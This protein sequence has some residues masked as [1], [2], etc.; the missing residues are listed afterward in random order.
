MCV[1]QV[2]NL[3]ESDSTGRIYIFLQSKEKKREFNSERCWSMSSKSERKTEEKPIQNR[4][5]RSKSVDEQKSNPI[6]TNWSIKKD[7]RK[8]GGNTK[9][10][11]TRSF[12][13]NSK[14]TSSRYVS[15]NQSQ[16]RPE[17]VSKVKVAFDNE[18]VLQ[19]LIKAQIEYLFSDYHLTND[20]YLLARMQDN[21]Q[22]W[23]SIDELCHNQKIRCLTNKKER[24]V[25]ALK[26][27][28]YLQLSP[29]HDRVRRPD[30][31]LPKLKPN[32]D[33]RRTVFLYGI[34]GNKR[35][36]EIRK[37]LSQYGHIKRIHFDDTSESIINADNDDEAP[38]KSVA[39]LIMKKKFLFPSS[40]SSRHGAQSDHGSDTDHSSYNNNGELYG[41]PVTNPNGDDHDF[42]HLKTCF[43][44]F[45]SQSQATKCVRARVR[46]VDGMRCIHKYDYNKVAKKFRT[47]QMKGEK[48]TFTPPPNAHHVPRTRYN[49]SNNTRQYQSYRDRSHNN[50]NSS[51]NRY[52]PRSRSSN[53]A[54]S[55]TSFYNAGIGRKKQPQ[56]PQH[57][58][59]GRRADRNSHDN[60][61]SISPK[62][63][64][65]QN[66]TNNRKRATVR[67]ATPNMKSNGAIVP[68]HHNKPR[69]QSVQPQP[70]PQLYH[71]I[72]AACTTTTRQEAAALQA[73]GYQHELYYLPMD[74]PNLNGI[75]DDNLYD[76][77]VA[78]DVYFGVDQHGQPTATHHAAAQL[79]AQS[80]SY[81]Q[82]HS[83][84]QPRS[85]PY[86]PITTPTNPQL[87]YQPQQWQLDKLEKFKAAKANANKQ[88]NTAKQQSKIAT[89]L[90]VLSS[91]H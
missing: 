39:Q 41:H 44:V 43:V 58:R 33:L 85:A 7:V 30:F 57:H 79:Q 3:F 48:L 50:S 65:Y 5:I 34:A 23:L 53:N 28:K 8:N 90:S 86:G 6:T 64:I 40:S 55:S 47:A 32:R 31:T 18:L 13:K 2:L 22:H 16:S 88:Q 76:P 9:H 17:R 63:I 37:L 74:D 49:H 69:S 54:V 10:S 29:Q 51:S 45:E 78:Y 35:E 12:I 21:P 36:H 87:Q 20:T 89:A 4:S 72:P 67:S 68:P 38:N 66:P 80:Q 19:T 81:A 14:V 26:E 42:S 82:Q 25:E 73:A 59:L 91:N 60:T 75:M 27:S 15:A 24:I 84:S 52:T 77:L 70:Q 1:S 46:A 62:P 61:A 83:Y 71:P 56:Q 11:V